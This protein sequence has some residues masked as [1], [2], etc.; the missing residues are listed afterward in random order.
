MF[1]VLLCGGYIDKT[2]IGSH[3]GIYILDMFIRKLWL[4]NLPAKSISWMV[5]DKEGCVSVLMV[6]KGPRD[7]VLDW[8]YPCRSHAI[9]GVSDS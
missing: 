6:E 5:Q 1:H 9:Y 3:H 2:Y 8:F 7:C 4:R